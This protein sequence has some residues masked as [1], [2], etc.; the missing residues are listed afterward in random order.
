MPSPFPGM[1][2]YLEHGEFFPELHGSLIYWVKD[3]LQG[4]LPEPYFAQTSARVWIEYAERVVEPDVDVLRGDRPSG[5]TSGIAQAV[6]GV[7][8]PVVV[9]VPQDETTEHF[10]EVRTVKGDQHLVTSIEVLSPSN[11]TS[12]SEGRTQYLKKQRQVLGSQV[13]LVE[14]DLLRGGTHTTAVR[15]KDA[16]TI[17]GPFDYHIC[18]RAFEELQQARIYPIQLRQPLPRI[19]IPLLPGDQPV[20]LDL[21]ALFDRAYDSG[22]YRRRSPYRAHPPEPVLTPEQAAWAEQL[23]REKGLLPR[24]P[25]RLL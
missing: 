19:L 2:P 21:Q 9:Y 15:L 24:S 4:S 5:A 12:G 8:V 16:L 1:D 11:K 14:I 20:P 6:A 18:V 17:A 25:A 13:N 22:P 7:N 3:S 10:V 23:L